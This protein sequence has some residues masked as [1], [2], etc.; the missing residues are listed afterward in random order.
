MIEQPSSDAI[1]AADAPDGFVPITHNAPF[2]AHTGPYFDKET[3]DGLVRGFR[4]AP[5][6]CNQAR[7][8]HGGMLMTFIDVVLGVTMWRVTGR[9][10]VT[11]S[12][13]TDFV[14][15]AR[16]GDW[17]EGR[18]EVVRSTRTLVF[19]RGDLTCGDRTVMTASGVFQLIAPRS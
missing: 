15:A 14:S 5:H 18:G 19:L 10:G 2:G 9:P 6:H 12:L 1:A 11:V 13:A 3:E 4:V 8:A 7:I 17:V 16:E